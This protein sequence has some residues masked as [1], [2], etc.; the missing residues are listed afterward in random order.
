MLKQ[1]KVFVLAFSIITAS[2]FGYVQYGYSQTTEETFRE[3]QNKVAIIKAIKANIS[4]EM[5]E[6]GAK[7]QMQG[8]ILFKTPMSFK[9]NLGPTL[10]IMDGKTKTV[11]M[12]ASQQNTAMKIEMD[13]LM[14]QYGVS[15]DQLQ[16]VQINP[17]NPFSGLKKG[18]VVFIGK[19]RV[20]G[21][22][23]YMFRGIIDSDKPKLFQSEGGSS[24]FT[25][26]TLWL[27]TNDGMLRKLIAR[28][29][30]PADELS[31]YVKNV[32]VNPIIRE[33]EF[34]FSPPKEAQVLDMT[35]MME[36]IMQQN[37]KK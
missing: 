20:N 13:R 28:G 2:L 27:S 30:N 32:Q 6:K 18:S 4:I 11:W 15:W 7:T 21:E 16:A 3:I 26:M 24:Q 31:I 12:Y 36:Q 17:E 8:D 29:D 5:Q 19:D 37:K 14:T 22:P 23:T 25:K 35:S 34:L 1:I 33:E 9:L 10:V